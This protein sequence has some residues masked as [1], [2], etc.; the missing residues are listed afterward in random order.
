MKI[1]RTVK[2]RTI[3]YRVF[4]AFTG[5]IQLRY[6]F[7]KALGVVP[8]MEPEQ[9]DTQ[10]LELYLDEHYMEK[11]SLASISKQMHI[12]RTKLCTLANSSPRPGRPGGS[13]C[14]R[15]A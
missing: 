15:G 6:C 8:A 12:G 7:R 3:F 9:T 10:R 5:K 1:V 4:F 11:L 2:V 14:R 13:F